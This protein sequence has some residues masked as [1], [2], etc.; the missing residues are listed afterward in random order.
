MITPS[1]LHPGDTILLVATARK[2]TIEEIQ[3]AITSIENLGF[4][5]LLSPN[6]FE[7]DNQFA[8]TDDMRAADLQWAFDHPEAKAIWCIRGG[9]GTVRIIDRLDWTSFLKQPKWILGYSDV[10]V[11]HLALQKRGVCSGHTTMPINFKSNSTEAVLSAID[12]LKNKFTPLAADTHPLNELG[13]ATGPLIGGNLS[14]LY[15]MMGS[16]DIPDLQGAILYIEDLDEYLYHIDR[17]MMQLKRAGWLDQIG[18]IMVGGMS[19][20]NDNTIPFGWSAEEI[21][22]HHFK[23]YNKPLGFGFSFGHIDNNLAIAS[24]KSGNFS[25]TSSGSTLKYD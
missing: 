14:I 10:T 20:M 13:Q 22:A 18:G 7:V 25:V 8:G 17:M 3:P 4:K 11:L 21:I 15:S 19:D 16:N 5:V 9:Y 2:A 6:L 12:L 24:G 1:A 23:P